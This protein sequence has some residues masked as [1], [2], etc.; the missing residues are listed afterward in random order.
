MGGREFGNAD[1]AAIRQTRQRIFPRELGVDSVHGHAALAHCGI[2]ERHWEAKEKQRLAENA[3]VRDSVRRRREV[4]HRN[5]SGRVDKHGVVAANHLDVDFTNR[6]AVGISRSRGRVRTRA[7]RGSDQ[8]E[9]LMRRRDVLR[10]RDSGIVGLKLG[11]H[12]A[13]L[14]VHVLEPLL[15]GRLCVRIRNATQVSALDQVGESSD[16][17]HECVHVRVGLRELAGL[18]IGLRHETHQRLQMIDEFFVKRWHDVHM[19]L[20]GAHNRLDRLEQIFGKLL[21]IAVSIVLKDLAHVLVGRAEMRE[22]HREH[23]DHSAVDQADE[24]LLHQ[25][26]AQFA[27]ESRGQTAHSLV[28]AEQMRHGLDNV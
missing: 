28:R 19:F 16:L 2:L 21:M 5:N 23:L 14:E 4:A 12:L 3:D 8:A 7:G 1:S 27:K 11:N 24:L 10:A 15:L 26:F 20:R 17:A 6:G 22:V 9:R 25:K 18:A 13:K